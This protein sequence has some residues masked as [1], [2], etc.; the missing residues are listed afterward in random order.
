VVDASFVVQVIWA[1]LL[2]GVATT[3][4]MAGP[5][6]VVVAKLAGAKFVAGDVALLFD[7]STEVTRK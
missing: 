6:G 3:V 7:E 5:V 4:E 2:P 1:E